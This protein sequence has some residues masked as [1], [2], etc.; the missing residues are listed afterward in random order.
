MK[1]FQGCL[2][3]LEIGVLVWLPLTEELEQI[4]QVKVIDAEL[5][6]LKHD[7]GYNI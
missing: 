6:I 3:G 4:F 1:V 7:L 5:Y 2:H